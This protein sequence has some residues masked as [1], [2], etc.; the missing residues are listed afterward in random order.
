MIR[1]MT[2]ANFVDF[3]VWLKSAK[4]YELCRKSFGE[5]R[6]IRDDPAQLADEFLASQ[7]ARR[8]EGV[9][10]ESVPPSPLP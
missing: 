6:I 7:K 9:A 10:S 2:K 5:N 3:L 8:P 1:E 4:D